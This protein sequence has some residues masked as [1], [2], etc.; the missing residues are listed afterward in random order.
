[1]VHLKGVLHAGEVAGAVENGVHGIVRE[2][3]NGVIDGEMVVAAKV[4]QLAVEIVGGAVFAQHF[5]GAVAD[6][7]GGVGYEL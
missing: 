5:E 6:A 7:F 2:R 3:G 4:F 1:M